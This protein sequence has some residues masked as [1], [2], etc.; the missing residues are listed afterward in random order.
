MPLVSVAVPVPSLDLLTYR[1]PE[2]LEAPEVGARV[3]VPLGNR[4]VTGIV[5][6]A[7]PPVPG[8]SDGGQVAIRDL[9]DILDPE[10][11]LP[12]TVVGLARWVADYY[13]CGPGD[14]LGA[15]MPPFA[16]VESEWRARITAAGEAR[17]AA[18]GAG[19]RRTLRDSALGLLTGASWV[20]VRSVAYRL[21]HLDGSRRGRI[22][23]ARALVRALQEEGLVEIEDVLTGQADAFK[24][25]RVAAVTAAGLELLEPTS[26]K[27]TVASVG[28]KQREALAVLAGVPEGLP[29]SAL[30]ERGL[31]T[32]VV[33]R[34]ASRGLVSLRRD[35]VDRDPFEAATFLPENGSAG[36]PAAR[37][38]TPEQTTALERLQCLLA[39]GSFATALLHGVTGSGKTELYL[40][41][42]AAVRAAGRSALILVPEIGLTPAL[43]GVFRAAFGDHV[44]IQH[45]GLS[46][47]ERYDQWQRIRRGEVDVVVGTRSAVFAP[48]RSVGLIIVDEEHDGSYK[49]EDTPRYHGRDVAVM[50]GK[51]EDA[52]VVLGSATPSIES[53]QNATTGRY[54]MVTMTRR[55]LDRPLAHVTIVNMRDEF[56]ERGPDVVLSQPLLEGIAARLSRKEQVL[57]LLNRRGYATAV[58]CRQC[59]ATIDCPNCSV[60]LTVHSGPR[61]TRRAR[62]H[63]CNYSTVVPKTCPQCAAPYLDQAG[64]GTERVEREILAAFP[65]ARVERLDR[66][67]IRRRG[68]AAALLSRFGRAEIDV[69]VGTQMIAKGHDFPRVTLVGVVSADVGLGLADFRAAERTFQ[70]LTQVVGRAGRGEEPGEAIIQTLYPGHYSIRHARRQDYRAFFDEELIFRRAMQYPPFVALTSGIVRGRSLAAAMEDAET[71]VGGLRQAG[72]RAG[73]LVLGPAP[74]PFVKLRGE[75][76]AQFF[77]KGVR[78]A[79]MREA[80]RKALEVQPELRRRVAIDVDPMTVL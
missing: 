22:V 31:S 58:F 30:R 5:V 66:D 19:G 26:R 34:L 16:W 10:P 25:I 67:T 37:E 49:Q 48:L 52:L 64:F 77:I 44:A 73:F 3:L 18:L 65:S 32:D 76:R 17:L 57:V 27:D 12:Q 8:P 2:G 63:Y 78:R 68:A 72:G 80:V 33:Q 39:G 21:E 43:A 38:L 51:R 20:P 61:D 47:G 23:P 55:V 7:K 35:Q 36:D 45:S 70:L 46:D 75:H 42:T 60:S 28:P 71:I 14:A 13:A 56:A 9:L 74:A 40:R 59:A 11:F 50:R 4:R 6:D 79:T 62:C 15:A 69:L 41:L 29:L 54:E 24:T 1:V 53:Y